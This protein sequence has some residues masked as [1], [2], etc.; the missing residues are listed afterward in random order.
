MA[1]IAIHP[2]LHKSPNFPLW[3]NSTLQLNSEKT[4][5]ILPSGST[6]TTGDTVQLSASQQYYS[7]DYYA[8]YPPHTIQSAGAQW[9]VTAY[10]FT[11]SY[12]P[13]TVVKIGENASILGTDGKIR[14]I[15]R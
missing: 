10:G 8:V 7:F 15:Y 3:Q 5:N 1:I 12:D 6:I 13:M 9:Y 14:A 11:A 4:E 2:L